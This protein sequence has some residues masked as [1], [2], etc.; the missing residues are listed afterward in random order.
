MVGSTGVTVIASD[1]TTADALA[2]T[3]SVLGPQAGY[4][5]V[6]Q[7]P[8]CSARFVWHEDGKV[9]VRTSSQWSSQ[10][11]YSSQRKIKTGR[12]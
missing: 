3:L 10:T 2:T 5:F 8:D 4:E 11:S 7:T 1:A 6:E 12:E 9:R